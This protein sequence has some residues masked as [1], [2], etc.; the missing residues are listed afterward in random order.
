MVIVITLKIH[1]QKRQNLV[2]SKNHQAKKA[3]AKKQ[4]AGGELKD[5]TYNLEEKNYENNYRVKMSMTVAGG[6]V[7]K[8]TYDY[9]DKDGK[10]KQDDKTY[11]EKNEESFKNKS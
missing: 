3:T 8:T 6:K 1:L 4:V 11:N 2:Q 10:S 7:T 5:G 9:V